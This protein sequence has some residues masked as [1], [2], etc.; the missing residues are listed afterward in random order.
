MSSKKKMA[1]LVSIKPKSMFRGLPQRWGASTYKAP[2]GFLT[3]DCP[4]N[5]TSGYD[6]LLAPPQTA[7][8][9]QRNSA[10]SCLLSAWLAP[11]CALSTSV[12]L[13]CRL[14]ASLM[15]TRKLSTFL[16]IYQVY[17]AGASGIVQW[18]ATAPRRPLSVCGARYSGRCSIVFRSRSCP[19][20]TQI[21]STQTLALE[22]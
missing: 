14:G 11:R 21:V 8:I 15:L 19:G 16:K 17:N 10:T 13:S 18:H 4:A 5:L 2:D 3:L 12:K 9:Q 6:W 22:K 20:L 1:R 7:E